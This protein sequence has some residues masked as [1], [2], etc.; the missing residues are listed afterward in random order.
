MTDVTTENGGR[1]GSAGREA[2]QL[3]LLRGIHDRVVQPLAAASMVLGLPELSE[4]DRLC[5]AAA[6][7]TALGELGGLLV[8][9]SEA[10]APEPEPDVRCDEAR[11]ATVVRSVVAEAL[12]NV[13]KH[14]SPSEVTIVVHGEDDPALLLD[15]LNDGVRAE[16]NGRHGVGLRL[17]ELEASSVGAELQ[18]GPTGDGAWRLRMRLGS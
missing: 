5:A 14:S 7:T 2:A 11:L 13:R 15:V 6:V 8:G 18:A 16:P 3:E 12:V 1:A 4:E 17:A 9:A 10:I